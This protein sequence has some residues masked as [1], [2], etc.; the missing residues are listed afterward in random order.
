M[1]AVAI[2]GLILGSFLVRSF[3]F[4][5]LAEYYDSQVVGVEY[6][7][8]ML[9]P[10]RLCVVVWFDAQGREVSPRQVLKD[11][12]HRQLSSKYRDAAARPWLPV[13]PDP[14]ALVP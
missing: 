1:I 11:E 5:R 8:V 12:S 10:S 9:K 4:W 6:K 3:L 2:V 7:N 14:L 13:E